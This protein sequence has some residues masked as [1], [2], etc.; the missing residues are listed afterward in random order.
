[1]CLEFPSG[2]VLLLDSHC[3]INYL[4]LLS[5][6]SSSIMSVT[7]DNSDLTGPLTSLSIK[8]TSV[9]PLAQKVEKTDHELLLPGERLLNGKVYFL[10]TSV[11]KNGIERF[12]VSVW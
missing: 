12:G 4:L 3:F 5:G 7:D 6:L 10:A 9:G 11:S 2:K 8:E 1:M